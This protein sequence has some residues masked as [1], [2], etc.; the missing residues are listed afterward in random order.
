MNT[1]ISVLLNE[2]I[3]NIDKVN[4]DELIFTLQSGG[5]ISNVS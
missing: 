2:I 4:N 1:Q 5:S 3:T